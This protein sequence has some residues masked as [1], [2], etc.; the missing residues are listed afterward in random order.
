MLM[1]PFLFFARRRLRATSSCCRPRQLP[2]ELQRRQLR[3]PAAGAGLLQVRD[4]GPGGDGPAVPAAGGDPGLTRMG[5]VTPAQ[6]RKNRRYA[7]LV[8][9]VIA[10]LLPGA[11]PVTMLMLMVPLLVLFEGSILL[12]AL[13]ERRAARARDEEA[14][15]DAGRRARPSTP[16]TMLFDL[17]GS[18]PPQGRQDH[19]RDARPPDGR[20]PGAVRHRRQRVCGGLL[21]AIT[22]QRRQRRAAPTASSKRVRGAAA[23]RA[24]TRRTRRL[25][26]RSRARASTSPRRR[27]F[28]QTTRRRTPTPGRRSCARRGAPGSAPRARRHK[29]DDARRQ[30]DGPGL[31]GARLNQ[32]AR[33]R[34]RRRSYRAAPRTRRHVRA[35]RHARLPGGPDPQGRPGGRQGARAA[36]TDM[37]ETLKDQLEQAKQQAALDARRRRAADAVPRRRRQASGRYNAPPSAPVA[38]LAEQRTLNPKVPGSIPGGGTSSKPRYGAVSS[39]TSSSRR[40]PTPAAASLAGSS[41][42]AGAAPAAGAAP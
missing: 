38:Q 15:G 41:R 22:E 37:R 18:R 21:D 7:I 3:H 39:L 34:R 28:D 30:P 42:H 35:A 23:A 6:L 26:R 5:I 24:R 29:P 13:L 27:D 1:V 17:R 32:P 9:A 4:P 25:G 40:A 20:R 11:G 8:I 12:A 33:R 31:R 2:A 10:A 19:L 16:T 14:A 36:R